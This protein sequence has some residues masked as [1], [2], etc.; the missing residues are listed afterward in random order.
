VARSPRLGW[1][2]AGSIITLAGCKT[3]KT[4]VALTL[5]VKTA[6]DQLRPE[7]VVMSWRGPGGRDFKQR[8]PA[9]PK[10]VLPAIGELLTTILIDVDDASADDR[11]VSVEGLKTVNGAATPVSGVWSFV[12]V[13]P[14]Q[15]VE[16]ILYLQPWV[17]SDR[18]DLPDSLDCALA[19][20]C[21]APDG[22]AVDAG[23]D[24]AVTND[25]GADATAGPDAPRG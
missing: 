12:E 1:L 22:G 2:L 25:G 18:N 9:D 23:G 3:D 20:T 11:I 8:V 14:G 4:E 13:H 24:D 7:Y 5:K 16:V 17:D 6:E 19:G 10:V 21:A 15:R